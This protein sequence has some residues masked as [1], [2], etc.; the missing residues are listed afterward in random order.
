MLFYRV[1]EPLLVSERERLR[2]NDF[3][4]LLNNEVFLAALFACS[5]EVVLK[6]HSLITISYPFLLDHLRVNAFHFVTTSES[7]VKYAPK[8]PAALKKHMGDVK[9]R[10]LDSLVWRSDSALYQLL[11]GVRRPPTSVPGTPLSAASPSTPN[12]TDRLNGNGVGTPSGAAG[13]APYCV[14]FSVWCFRVRLPGFTSFATF[15]AWTLRTKT[16]SGLQ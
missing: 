7:F 3:S 4:K 5:A 13:H 14:S 10:I 15:S 9:N 8:L 2:N 6:A 1:L 16:R 12:L 11:A